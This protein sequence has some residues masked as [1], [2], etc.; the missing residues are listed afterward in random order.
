MAAILPVAILGAVL[1]YDP[2]MM[3][4]STCSSSSLIYE[5]K[6]VLLQPA[7]RLRG[8]FSFLQPP[9][10]GP[11]RRAR[12]RQKLLKKLANFELRDHTF[13]YA[14]VVIYMGAVVPAVFLPGLQHDRQGEHVDTNESDEMATAQDSEADAGLTEPVST[15]CETPNR[16]AAAKRRVSS[17][18]RSGVTSGSRVVKAVYETMVMLRPL[19]SAASIT[20]V[21][22]GVYRASKVGE[23]VPTVDEPVPMVDEP[24]PMPAAA[25]AA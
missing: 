21:L 25:P 24:A 12:K 18:V 11:A 15:P 16:L 20:L 22:A 3:A 14:V 7:T 6:P 19:V 8:G 13:F 10:D 23:P 9:N 5:P 4:P 17:G 2:T 1:A